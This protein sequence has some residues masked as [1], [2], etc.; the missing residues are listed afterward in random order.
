MKCIANVMPLNLR[1]AGATYLA[2]FLPTVAFAASAGE[3]IGFKSLRCLGT[4]DTI[5]S[6]P[7]TQPIAYTGSGTVATLVAGESAKITFGGTPFAA[8]QFVHAAGTQPNTYFALIVSGA[9]NGAFFTV[10][11]N[12]TNSITLDLNGDDLSTNATANVQI[13]P[14]WTLGTVFPAG[15]AL[16]A[17][18]SILLPDV[19]GTGIDR[20]PKGTYVFDSNAG[21]WVIEGAL[22]S[23]DDTIL[24]PDTQFHRA[25]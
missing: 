16:N 11:G 19:T 4:S 6:L 9:R 8:A 1:I 17:N 12:D 2:A 14:Y 13:V 15:G 23:Q 20:P 10:T 5:V 18:T 7:L 24:F 22:D 21:H 3:P 25:Q